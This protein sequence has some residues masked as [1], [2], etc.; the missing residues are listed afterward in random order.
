MMRASTAIRTGTKEVSG[1][2]LGTKMLLITFRVSFVLTLFV[3]FA[4]GA[5]AIMA[6]VGGLTNAGDPA[7]M[8]GDWFKAITGR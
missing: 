2:S 3:L 8:V 4:I 7:M 6:L 1:V 5:W